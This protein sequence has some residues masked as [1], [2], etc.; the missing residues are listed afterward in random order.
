MRISRISVC[1]AAWLIVWGAACP[2]EDHPPIPITFELDEPAF[3]TLVIED[4]N[5]TRVRNLVSETHFPA[6]RNV[7]WWD[8][9]DDVGSDPEAAAHAVYHVPGKFVQPGRYI[10]RGLR[11]KEVNLRYELCV[12]NPG[13]PPW[14]TADTSSEWLTNH[15]P[16]GTVCFVPADAAPARGDAGSPPQVL[17]GSFVAE[18]GSGL[19]WVDLDGNKLHGQMWVGGVWTGA[20]FIARDAGTSHAKGV[21]AYVA[22]AWKGDKYNDFKAE[23]RLHKLVNDD[24]KLAAPRDRRFGHGEDPPVLKPTWK[25]PE[26]DKAGLGGLAAHNGLVVLSLPKMNALLLVDAI[27]GKALHTV[28]LESPRGLAFDPDGRL[29]A[30]SGRRVVRT[31]LPAREKCNALTELAAPETL[32]AEGLEDPQQITCGPDGTMYVSDWGTSN[33]VKVFSPA[34]KLLFAIGTPGVPKAGPYDETQMH[35]PKGITIDSRGNLWV[36]EEDHQPKRVSVWTT[37]G[38]FVRAFYGPPR[39]GGGGVLDPVDK[40][41]FYLRGMTF[42][43]DWEKGTSKLV[44]IRWR[45]QPDDFPLPTGHYG[46]GPPDTPIYYWGRKYFTNC[47]SSNPTNGPQVTCIWV[48]R[49]G[50]A[51][52][53]AAFG[54]A[55]FWKWLAEEPQ[56]SKI[57][58]AEKPE[59]DK[60]LG[61]NRFMFVW[62]DLNGDGVGQPDEVQVSQSVVGSG[63]LV[64]PDLSFVTGQA[65]RFAPLGFTKGGAPVY[66]LRKG[67]VLCPKTQRP[68]S[69]GGGQVL[70]GKGDWVVLTTA[71]EPF[72]REAVGGAKGGV[73]RWSYPS[74]WPGLHASH[75]APMPEF[76]GELIGT[77]RLIG[78]AFTLGDDFELWAI[79]GNKGSIYLFTMDGLFV[80]TLFQDT[81]TP[82]SSW[83]ERT[84]AV[85]GMSVSDLTN[86]EES[87][88]PSITRTSDGAVYVVTRYPAIIRV[89]GLE[90]LR[91]IP[92]TEI[93]VTP[94]ML[95]EARAYHIAT[96]LKRRAENEVQ[97]TLVVPILAEAPK[98][99]GDLGEW[100]PERFVTIDVRKKSTGDWSRRELKTQAAL[101]VSGDRLYG[102]FRTGERSMLD[103][104]GV[105]LPNLFKTG[106][107]LDIMLGTDPNADP[108]RKQAV[109][110]DVRLLI[111]RVKGKTV[112]VL[113]RPVAPDAQGERIPF[114]SPL[115]TIYFDDVRDVSDA[116]ALANGKPA[117]NRRVVPDPGGDFEFSVPLSVLGLAPKPGMKIRGDVGVLR[118]SRIETTQRA[119]W[120]NKATGLVSDIPSEAE[121]LPRLW[122]TFEFV[123]P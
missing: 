46:D 86:G 12:Y 11:R 88:W 9:L 77:T 22:S 91:R 114:S 4:T 61:Q 70:V 68:S 8:G 6:G 43:L 104:A 121:L 52:P 39:Y 118:G 93:E 108:E 51:V 101:A 79:N 71:P 87:F 27:E 107:A 1:V 48:E 102:A 103:N 7:V 58:F 49:N 41:L 44:A 90:T 119:Y 50:V 16:P 76:P 95:K 64:G 33:Q 80:A 31:V 56:R 30:V 97:T 62:S 21:Y 110:G 116:V 5:G 42:R 25:F 115:R 34:G 55:R 26:A 111:A 122:G 18:G 3:V 85:R 99:D 60:Q 20:Q 113:Y 35:H 96:E 89:E 73:A 29:L 65:V 10:V 23:I 36:A 112:A 69:T 98:V 24:Q 57:P 63:V 66:D 67:E 117:N 81:R 120:T 84:E 14:R 45:P 72:A 19:A 59:P 17:I 105:S 109:A 54:N 13:K 28:P 106:G 75:I 37:K 15:T 47:Y 83:S 92:A 74:P 100:P 78:P 2:A 94:E 38:E 40:T 82:H 53:V 32:V 123:A